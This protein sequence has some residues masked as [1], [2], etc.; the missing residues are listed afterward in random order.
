LY[1]IKKIIIPKNGKKF[2][3]AFSQVYPFEH[4]KQNY[5][6]KIINDP[7]EKERGRRL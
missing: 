1:H 6:L 3:G 5:V 7:K 2:Q 4:G